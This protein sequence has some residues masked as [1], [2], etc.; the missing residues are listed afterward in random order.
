MEWWQATTFPSSWRFTITCFYLPLEIEISF[1]FFE[2][3]NNKQPP[4]S[5]SAHLNSCLSVIW[6]QIE[7]K[8]GWKWPRPGNKN[9]QLK[10]QKAHTSLFP[11]IMPD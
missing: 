1:C 3:I 2:A 10:L 5:E 11:F 4:Q 9:R 6:F 8:N 7:N